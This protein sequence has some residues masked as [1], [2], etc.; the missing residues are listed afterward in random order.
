[1][2]D[3]PLKLS[4]R[5]DLDNGVRL[6]P[7]KVKLLALIES[8]GSIRAAG[9]AM[10]MSYRRA[11]LLA[12]EINAMFIMPSI[13]TRHGGKSGGGAALSDFGRQMLALARR[14][15]ARSEAA[16]A[17]ELQ[18][19]AQATNRAYIAPQKKTRALPDEKA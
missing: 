17:Q 13:E 4:F 3:T 5:I 7:G 19:I 16:V 9:A 15:E 18:Q 8:H 14:I 12:D 10:G 11:W 2:S 1:M 6:G